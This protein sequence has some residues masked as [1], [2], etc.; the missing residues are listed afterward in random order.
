MEDFDFDLLILLQDVGDFFDSIT[1]EF[2][3]VDETID[4]FFEG[5]EGSEI[6]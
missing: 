5:D 4:A 1:S 3:D 2:G 6:D